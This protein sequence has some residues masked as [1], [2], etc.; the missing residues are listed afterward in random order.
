[1]PANYATAGGGKKKWASGKERFFYNT[2]R[3]AIHLIT[4]FILNYFREN[5]KENP[6]KV[7]FKLKDVLK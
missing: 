6:I 5:P 7:F 1:V 3:L 4:F 2:S